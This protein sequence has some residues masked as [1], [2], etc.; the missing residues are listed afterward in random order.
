MYKDIDPVKQPRGTWRHALNAVI[1]D[2]DDYGIIVSSEPSNYECLDLEI[3]KIV[4]EIYITNGE[5]VLFIYDKRYNTSIIGILD[6]D[7]NWTEIVNEPKL[8]F[9]PEYPIK[10]VF[11]I[12]NGCD[13]VIYWTDDYNVP[14][15]FNLSNPNLFKDSSGNWDIDKFRLLADANKIPKFDVIEVLDGGGQLISGSYNI[16]VQLVDDDLNGTPW[17]NFSDVIK[18]YGDSYSSRWESIRGSAKYDIA[19]KMFPVCNKSIR[20]RVYNLDESYKFVRFAVIEAT[21]GTGYPTDIKVSNVISIN[22]GEAEWIYSGNNYVEKISYEELLTNRM[23]I[24]S[25]KTIE[26]IENRL[27][28][29]NIKEEV[30]NYCY[31]QKYASKIRADCIIKKVKLTDI[32]NKFSPKHPLAVAGY[33]PGEIYSFGIVYVLE[34]GSKTPAFHIPGRNPKYAGITDMSNPDLMIVP[35]SLNNECSSA[36]YTDAHGCHDDDYDYWGVDSEGDPLLGKPIRHH[37]FP[38]RKEYNIPLVNEQFQF[39]NIVRYSSHLD[40]NEKKKNTSATEFFYEVEYTV[41]GATYYDSGSGSIPSQTN[42]IDIVYITPYFSSQPVFTKLTIHEKDANGNVVQVYDGLPD[43]NTT[44]YTKTEY[45]EYPDV[46]GYIFGIRF[47]NIIKPPPVNGKEVIGYYIVRNERTEAEQTIVD[48]GVFFKSLSIDGYIVSSVLNPE[49]SNNLWINDKVN[50]D[51]FSFLSINHKFNYGQLQYNVNI[52]QD[53]GYRI[54]NYKQ[55]SFYDKWRDEDVIDGSSY[56]PNIHSV[57]DDDGWSLKCI[58]KKPYLQYTT[59]IDYDYN[60][61]NSDIISIGYVSAAD[62]ININTSLGV[63]KFVNISMDNSIGVISYKDNIIV[64]DKEDFCQYIPYV[65]LQ[66]DKSEFYPNFELLPYYKT[67]NNYFEVFGS[68]VDIFGGDVYISPL[69]Y[70]NMFHYDNRIAKRDK[71]S[72]VGKVILA[73]IKTITAGALI[74]FT[75]GAMI[76]TAIGLIISGANDFISAINQGKLNKMLNE[77]YLLNIKKTDHDD[78]IFNEFR[79]HKYR[80]CTGNNVQGPCDDEIQWHCENIANIWVE[81]K[82]NFSLRVGKVV[83]RIGFMDSPGWQQ[84]GANYC[85]ATTDVGNGE[86]C[87]NDAYLEPWTNAG[88]Y[89]RSKLKTYINNEYSYI[90]IPHAE[91]YIYNKDYNRINR[92]EVYFHL[93]PYWDCCSGCFNHFPHRGIYSEQS[94]Q[95]EKV[96]NYRVFL[97]NNYR[98]IEKGTGEVTNIFRVG[99]RLY[100]HTEEALWVLL[101]S[102]QE[103]VNKDIVTYI[104]TGEF[105]GIPPQAVGF[106]NMHGGC[107]SFR[108]L[109]MCKAGIFFISETDRKVYQLSDNRLIPISDIGM[110]DF[111]FHNIDKDSKYTITYDPIYNRIL[112]SKNDYYYIVDGDEYREKFC[113]ESWTISYSPSFKKWISFHSYVSH[114]S[115]YDN[116]GFYVFFDFYPKKLYKH[117]YNKEYRE[118]HGNICPF[119]I[120]KVY[121]SGIN[122]TIVENIVYDNVCFVWDG[123]DLVEVPFETF[124]KFIGYNSM[125]CTG[126]MDLVVR[127]AGNISSDYMTTRILNNNLNTIDVDRRDNLWSI[128][129]IRN[130]RI[131]FSEPM[132]VSECVNNTYWYINDKVVNTNAVSINGNIWNNKAIFIDKYLIARFIYSKNN[133]FVK[134]LFRFSFPEKNISIR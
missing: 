3:K 108:N 24:A 84:D 95:E 99:N 118:F 27:V 55:K 122:N 46:D 74:Y 60:A 104:G 54:V 37:R 89:S 56:D 2:A 45:T 57:A 94:F 125:Q 16:A 91:I 129:N 47:S 132:F 48:S 63:K 25:A 79:Y 10:G 38:L 14:R 40:Y 124:D 36:K 97:P 126:E 49:L 76:S 81:H 105:F 110:A 35:M 4:G 34:D 66:I 75:G 7:C 64:A 134:I 106:G 92:E 50:T 8:N 117:T 85:E 20:V 44:V 70:S 15:R 30:D 98:D 19:G 58:V 11:R 114:F 39:V 101:P 42:K 112:V 52:I 53:G 61:Q 18:I 77:Q 31:F 73:I 90:G 22:N 83:D 26:Q 21:G 67:H 128:N 130:N 29:W 82:L 12:R 87:L 121:S 123:D 111:F 23:R 107:L 41:N 115:F 78:Y 133:K 5:H 72:A 68:S 1:E 43:A 17:L 71:K 69:R 120:E 9:N 93:P 59:S 32:Y 88:K 86:Y 33:Q 116:T 109:V 102:R 6:S 80:V 51:I 13:K 65:Y 62:N 131:D 113:N 103:R 28:L 127:Q 96:D 100:I 119:I